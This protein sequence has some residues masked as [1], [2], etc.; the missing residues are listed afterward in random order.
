MLTPGQV[1]Q[2]LNISKATVCRLTKR[3]KIPHLRLGERIVRYNKDVIEAWRREW[4]APA[5]TKTEMP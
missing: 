3:G 5:E 4:Q 2:L 1:A